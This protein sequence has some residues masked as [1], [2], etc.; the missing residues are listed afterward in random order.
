MTLSSLKL[1][2]SFL[3]Y[4]IAN[5]KKIEFFFLVLCNSVIIP[6][7]R[8][9]LEKITL[10]NESSPDRTR[11]LAI[12]PYA[13]HQCLHLPVKNDVMMLLTYLE[14]AVSIYSRHDL[15]DS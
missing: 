12:W 3:R 7:I 15:H 6:V 11:S 9:R 2:H 1:F 5:L 10:K 13:N 4:L 14:F 8:S